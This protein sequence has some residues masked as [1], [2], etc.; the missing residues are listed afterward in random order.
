MTFVISTVTVASAVSNG[1]TLTFAYPAIP[2]SGLRVDSYGPFDPNHRVEGGVVIPASQTGPG[3]FKLASAH[4]AYSSGNAAL[5]VNGV[6]FTLTFN[7][8][9][10]GITFTYQGSSVIPVGSV[11]S[12]QLELVG[13]NDGAVFKDDNRI[14]RGALAPVQQIRLGAPIALSTT[15]VLATTAVADASLHTLATAYVADVPRGISA[16]SSNA[17][18]TTQT[19]TV[20]G[21]DEYGQAMTESIALNGTTGVNGKKAWKTIVSY[22][23]SASLAGNLSIGI[24][25]VLGLPILIPAAGYVFQEILDSAKNAN[26]GTTTAG[27]SGAVASATTGDVRGT[28]A[29]A[30]TLPNGTHTYELLVACPD[31]KSLGIPQFAG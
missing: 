5:L 1:G 26:A 11:V 18:D 20:R 7:A 17:G 15:A 24:T 8:E 2:A 30:T 21:F 9:A 16:V 10:S 29:P 23:A 28:Y 27:V 13:Q 19:V 22:Q 4:R 31:P 3:D 6:D 14:A 12:L 25:N